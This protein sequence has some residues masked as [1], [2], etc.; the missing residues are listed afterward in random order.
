MVVWVLVREKWISTC[1]FSTDSANEGVG[2]FFSLSH[3]FVVCGKLD[4][5][6]GLQSG[7]MS[8]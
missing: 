7:G 6:V 3:I 1:S 5:I 8:T 4:T 2:F